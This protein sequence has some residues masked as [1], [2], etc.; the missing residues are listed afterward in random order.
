[1]LLVLVEEVAHRE[2]VEL[3]SDTSD[4]TGLSPSE[5]ELNL[6][7]RLLLKIVVDIYCS[8]LWVGHRLRIDLLRIEVSH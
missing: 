4:Y 1:M 6:V 5:R 3:E 8:V 7:V 2:I